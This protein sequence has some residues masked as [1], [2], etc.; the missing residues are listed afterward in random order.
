MTAPHFA[1]LVLI[2]FVWA[3]SLVAV[4]VGVEEMPPLLFTGLR[5]MI[6][7]LIL[8]PFLRWHHGQMVSI[9]IVAM[10]MGAIQFG[11]FFTGIYVADDLSSVAIASQLG[12][13]FTTLLSM[14]ILGETVGWRR[15]FGMALAFLGVMV[16]SFDPRVF[17]YI[18]GMAFGVAAALIGAMAIIVMRRL[19]NVGV[20]A[21]QAWIALLSWPLLLC[22]SLLIEG[23]PRDFIAAASL[24]T[25]A[26]IAFT[27]LVSNLIAH[28]GL[29]YLIQRYE[30]SRISPLTLLTPVFTVI[31]GVTVL[32][33]MLTMRMV[34]GGFITLCGV[35]IISLRRPETVLTVEERSAP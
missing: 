23:D 9:A 31:L 28:A 1:F 19:E 5:F 7:A 3:L 18:D 25:W 22:A 14:V 12:V 27:A 6:P 13:P 32:G 17:A 24:R 8:A 11:L 26:A 16:I 4:S 33:D 15:W 34:L 35:L 30:V 10:G 2:T 29:Y 21:L 20:F